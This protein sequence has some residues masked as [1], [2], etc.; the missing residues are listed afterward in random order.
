ME[1]PHVTDVAAV[2]TLAETGSEMGLGGIREVCRLAETQDTQI[3]DANPGGTFLSPLLVDRPE[4]YVFRPPASRVGENS[5][6]LGV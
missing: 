3:H 2:T 6:S 5:G 4:D 1:M